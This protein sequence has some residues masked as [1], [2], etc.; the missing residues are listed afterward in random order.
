[1]NLR[2]RLLLSYIVVIMATLV[3][4]SIALILFLNVRPAPPQQTYRDLT[5]FAQVSLRNLVTNARSG[6]LRRQLQGDEVFQYITEL[7]TDSGVRALLLNMPEQTVL[8]DSTGTYQPGDS[9]TWTAAPEVEVPELP[10]FLQNLIRNRLD[11]VYGTFLD[12]DTEE[13]LFIG[14]DLNTQTDEER[15]LIFAESAPTQTLRAALGQLG[16]S[17]ARPVFQAAAIGL[18]VA[19][20]MAYVISRTIAHPLQEIA[21]ATR[22]VNPEDRSKVP[23]TGPPEVR[24]VAEAINDMR[25]EVLATQTA[26]QDFIVNVSHDL[27]TPLTSIQGYSQAIMDGAANDPVKA[28]TIIHEEAARLN[29]MVTEL[30]DLTRLQNGQLSMQ[31]VPL[32]LSQIVEVVAQRLSIV[33]KDITLTADTPPMPEII[34]DGDRMAQVVT[35]LISN[36]IK[37]TPQGGTIRIRTQVNNGGVEL[38]VQDNGIGIPAAELPRI[39]ERFYQVDKTRGPRRGTGLGLAITQEIVQA[40]GGSISV[41][42]AGKNQ[43]STFTV[44]LPSPQLKTASSAR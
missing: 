32:Q 28:A 4:I 11:P 36:A 34:G 25:D 40:H 38:I 7:A 44:W 20:L 31:K 5:T 6:P 8:Y 23:V 33:A 18:L 43:G 12:P 41:T 42:S 22:Q 9:L 10:G 24:A 21:A 13:W 27:K 26:Q 16:S 15:L 3:I 30:T 39:F 14:L 37:H 35:N 1:M 17:L 2:A 29:R 19:A